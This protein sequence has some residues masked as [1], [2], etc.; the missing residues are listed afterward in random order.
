MRSSPAE[1]DVRA[2][3][4][5]ER[6]DEVLDFSR[7]GGRI[8]VLRERSVDGP[9]FGEYSLD[10]NCLDPG[11]RFELLRMGFDGFEACRAQGCEGLPP[12]KVGCV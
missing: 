5:H 10:L 3:M 11:Y 7:P 6:S 4:R 9:A 1:L 12:F 2:A 8:L